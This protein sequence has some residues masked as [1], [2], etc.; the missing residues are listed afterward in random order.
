MLSRAAAGI[1]GKTVIINLP[2]SPKG[3]KECLQV[4]I[5]SLEHGLDILLGNAA[6]CAQPLKHEHKG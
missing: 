4:V 5:G 6:E 2:G 3:V 1:R